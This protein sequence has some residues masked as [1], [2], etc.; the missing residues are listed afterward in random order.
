MHIQ[1]EGIV[2]YIR[3]VIAHFNWNSV[4][5]I[6]A[7]DNDSSEYSKIN[8][9]DDTHIPNRDVREKEKKQI[10]MN[11]LIFRDALTLICEFCLLGWSELS[12]IIALKYSLM[13]YLVS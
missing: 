10:H 6:I 3:V 7:I 8:I 13:K 11:N 2:Y 9:A 1:N 4:K 12:L 5:S